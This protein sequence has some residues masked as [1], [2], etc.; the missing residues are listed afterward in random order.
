MS[1]LS[2]LKSFITDDHRY[3]FLGTS[4]V[5]AIGIWF[6]M[7]R[8]SHMSFLRGAYAVE[9]A[10]YWFL[11]AWLAVSAVALVWKL[12]HWK[13][14]AYQRTAPFTKPLAKTVERGLVRR[15]WHHGSS[16]SSTV[17]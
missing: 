2:K 4:F 11:M 3:V 1:R 9:V 13:G 17:R 15:V 12:T 7:Q 6:S 5:A 8:R 16:C 14:D 10:M